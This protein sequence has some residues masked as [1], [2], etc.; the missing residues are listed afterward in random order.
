VFSDVAAASEAGLRALGFRIA[1]REAETWSLV[2]PNSRPARRTLRGD[3]GRITLS[4]AR[5]RGD[6]VGD[7]RALLVAPSASPGVLDAA[8]LGR[9]DVLLWDAPLAIVNG[10][11]YEAI[12]AGAPAD[13]PRRRD[14][15]GSPAPLT[16]PAPLPQ[17]LL[18]RL[19][20]GGS[21]SAGAAPAP[22]RHGGR[23]AWTRWAVARLLLLD[24]AAPVGRLADRL[25]VSRQAIS[26]ALAQWGEL[27]RRGHDG[28]WC[29]PDDAALL[30]AWSAAYPGPGGS[31]RGWRRAGDG[32]VLPD[33]PGAGVP[34][35]PAAP[36]GTAPPDAA[37]A[38]AVR[39]AQNAG[40][41]P[42][43]LRG[44]PAVG[45]AA[46]SVARLLVRT[47]VNL[48]R[49]GFVAVPVA[50]AELVTMVP[51]DP[52]PW[53]TSAPGLVAG[54]AVLLADRLLGSASVPVPR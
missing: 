18:S 11:A 24:G 21:G 14:R 4:E 3:R 29:A 37:L 45:D 49:A 40:A 20:T 33:P 22:A 54:G 44:D 53:A 41:A 16:Q 35:L 9:W 48:G 27:V 46:G 52:T 39:A 30:A 25:G 47:P 10:V 50:E 23:P 26:R 32:T 12:G 36:P 15:S 5:K 51:A 19:P 17:G 13:A 6:R 38:A 1:T 7:E 42:L 28:S 43:V 34:G 31:S 8:R 2:L